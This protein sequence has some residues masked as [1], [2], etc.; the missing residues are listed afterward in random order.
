VRLPV[1]HLQILCK[2]QP[3]TIPGFSFA[4]EPA[5]FTVINAEGAGGVFRFGG[6][7]PAKNG[8]SGLAGLLGFPD[9]EPARNRQMPA[10]LVTFA[11]LW[12]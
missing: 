8:Y 11:P 5:N 9:P 6:C 4:V 1:I 3:V 7:T 2:T 10:I 12:D